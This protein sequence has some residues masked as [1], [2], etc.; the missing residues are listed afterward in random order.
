MSRHPPAFRPT[1]SARRLV[2]RALLGL[3]ALVAV[4]LAAAGLASGCSQLPPL[5]GRTESRALA[6]TGDTRLGR[7]LAPLVAAHPG[8]SGVLPLADPLDAFAA[9]ALLADAAERSID[10]QYYI[11]KGDTS[12][13]LLL[14]R[15]RAAA[16]RGVRVRMLL[17]DNGTSGLDDILSAFDRHPRIEVRLFN[18]FA[19]RR[20][21][22][23]GYL[24]DFGRLNRRMHNK[25]FIVDNQ[26]SV[27]GGRNIGDA[28]F[29]AGTGPVFADLDVLAVGPITPEVS[30]DFDRYWA[31]ASAYP[32]AGLLPPA[33]PEALE[34][35]AAA[36]QALRASPGAQ[37]YLGRLRSSALVASLADGGLEFDWAPTRMVSDDPAKGLGDATPEASLMAQLVRAIGRPERE[38]ELVSAYF[39]PTD[40]GV[41]AFTR[42]AARGVAVTILTNSLEATD[43]AV[44][45][46]GY[47][48]HRRE[49]LEGGVALYEMRRLGP[50]GLDR[51]V[52]GASGGSAS[53]LHAKTFTVDGERVFV[54][55][56][57][58]DPRSLHLNTEL[59]FV[60]ESPALATSIHDGIV[61]R[62][63]ELA[64]RVTLDADGNLAWE[65]GRDGER[66]RVTTEPGASAWRRLGVWLLSWLPI[67]WML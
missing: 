56:F 39:V 4:L 10:V 28:Y 19:N 44:V 64:W 27:V 51:E 1:A 6:D 46:A 52:I 17:D 55:S 26:A 41:E 30:D 33:P 7:T 42:L 59:G 50:E 32:V 3:G 45:H 9:R 53:S 25:A 12:G 48:K 34:Q 62:L 2:R 66:T 38:L 8:V 37:D 31:S 47:A 60:I 13:R 49:L 58:F 11:W 20:L 65:S 63:P 18:P 67:D 29:A 40:A 22:L 23:L 54:G 43:V 16:D 21:R 24:G 57:N 14:D 5:E 35:F 61:R 36:V 15:L